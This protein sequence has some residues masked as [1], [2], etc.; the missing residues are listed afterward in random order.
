MN[1]NLFKVVTTSFFIISLSLS[2]N[3][4]ALLSSVD[5][6]AGTN[7]GL[8]TYDSQTNLQW[9]DVT[10]TVNQSF[11]DVRTGQWFKQG[12]RYATKSELQT[13]F[14]NAATPD[15]GKTHYFETKALID[16]LG[17]TLIA[18]DRYTTSGF[19]GTDYLGNDINL[20][21]HPIGLTFSAQL[22]KLDFFPYIGQAH[23]KGGHPFSNESGEWGS[24]LIRI[25][26]VPEPSSALL[27][28]AGLAAI[29]LRSKKT[30]SI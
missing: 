18:G 17:A 5:F 30:A 12:F 24:Y 28:M 29:T 15:D 7:D 22:G 2:T 8:L 10:Q 16:L 6:I 23:F 11:D 26:P 20:Q 4:F 27:F 3:A 13:L 19:I 9:L 25:A 21:S 1:A 14:K